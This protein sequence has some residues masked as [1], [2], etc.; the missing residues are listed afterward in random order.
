MN[1]WRQV[2]KE[3]IK[4]LCHKDASAGN[5]GKE[6][7]KSRLVRYLAVKRLGKVRS[8]SHSSTCG[9]PV[10]YRWQGSI[11]KASLHLLCCLCDMLFFNHPYSK[12][13]PSMI[14]IETTLMRL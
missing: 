7:R 5:K 6:I 12:A 8:G 4:M 1:E 13:I 2:H 10:R 3:A 11:T 9:E 14:N